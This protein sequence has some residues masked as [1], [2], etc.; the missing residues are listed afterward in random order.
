MTAQWNHCQSPT[1]ITTFQHP[2]DSSVLA[3]VRKIIRWHLP[4]EV[5][6]AINQQGLPVFLK[7]LL[8]QNG[9]SGGF[10]TAV[11]SW[12]GI[13]PKNTNLRTGR[14]LRI[15]VADCCEKLRVNW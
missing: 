11:V 15:D 9:N 5:R 12:S 7:Y 10:T 3:H 14:Q 8:F 1:W 6:S 13:T 4:I 2:H